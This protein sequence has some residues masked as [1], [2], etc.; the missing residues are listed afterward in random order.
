M[1]DLKMKRFLFCTMLCL[2]F[3]VIGCQSNT[4]KYSEPQ[5]LYDANPNIDMFVY[6]N[7][8]FVNASD[9]DWVKELELN[10][11]SLLG[12]IKE[13]GVS[14]GFK[15]WDAT[16]LE[17]GSNIYKSERS[18]ILLVDCNGSMIPYFKYVEG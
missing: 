7:T 13:T 9:V 18:D 3:F 17:V 16:L 1:E 2:L 6:E 10:K 15:D 5:S 14:T 8:A 11:D 12:T 4:S